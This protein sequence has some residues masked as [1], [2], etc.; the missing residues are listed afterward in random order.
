MEI[1]SLGSNPLK[2]IELWYREA[3]A[4]GEK[5][6]DAM[7]L[8]TCTSKGVPSVRMVLYKGMSKGGIQ[9]FTNFDSRKGQELISNP[10]AA[11]S[12]HWKT[13]DRQLRVEGRIRP[14]TRQESAA[15]FKSRARMSQ[16]GAWASRQ[17]E[18]L[19]SRDVLMGRVRHYEMLFQGQDVP[20]PP[21]WGGF[22]LIP[23]KVEF[24]ADGEFRLHDRFLYS[25]SKKTARWSR[26]RLFP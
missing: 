2:Q 22:R 16:I 11:L 19:A 20:L 13:L 7:A 9:L 24:W 3:V 17:S 23:E 12:F 8:A 21:H 1:T 4:S 15:Y 6:P 18:P 5:H 14:M 26:H 10:V 25:K